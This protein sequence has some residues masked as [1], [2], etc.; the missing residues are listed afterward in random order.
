MEGT[1][2]MVSTGYVVSDLE[3]VDVVQIVGTVVQ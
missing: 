1:I 2:L 3:V